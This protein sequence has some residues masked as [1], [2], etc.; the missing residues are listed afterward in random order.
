MNEEKQLTEAESMSIIQM[1][2]NSAKDQQKDDGK[3]WIIWGWLLFAASV[4]T[5]LNIHFKWFNTFFFWN[6]FGLT[7]IV[8]LVVGFIRKVYQRKQRGVKTYTSELFRRLNSGFFVSLWFI[9]LFINVASRQVTEWYVVTNAGF[10]LLVNLYAFWILV[11][12]AA[13]NFKPSIIGAYISWGIGVGMLFVHRFEYIMILH[14]IAV[15]IGYIIPGHIANN[16][17]NKLR[18]K[19]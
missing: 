9:I 6:L 5:V 1:M 3:G 17:F 16:E 19:G 14:G 18:R 13:M 7:A 10:A 8:L 15:L 2:I 4:S 12:G 11:Y